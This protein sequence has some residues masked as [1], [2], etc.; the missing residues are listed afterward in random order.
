MSRCG[1]DRFRN[2]TFS[3]FQIL[4]YS[5]WGNWRAGCSP[6][7]LDFFFLFSVFLTKLKWREGESQVGMD[8][9][10]NIKH[11]ILVLFL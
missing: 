2:E 10:R 9:C 1:T 7:A 5:S 4:P 3:W 8:T 11:G 6:C